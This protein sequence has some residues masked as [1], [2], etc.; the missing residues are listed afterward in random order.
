VCYASFRGSDRESSDGHQE[1]EEEGDL[2]RRG[3]DRSTEEIAA[4]KP[5][6]GAL[7]QSSA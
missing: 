3:E 1:V 5:A 4:R 7:F 2:T 6:Q